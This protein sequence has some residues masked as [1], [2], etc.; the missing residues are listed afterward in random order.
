MAK[1]VVED[2]LVAWNTGQ[3]VGAIKVK[4]AGKRTYKKV[5][6]TSAHEFSALL[7]LLQGPKIVYYD[8]KTGSFGTTKS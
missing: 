5:K 3:D 1:V 6:L 2:Y 4:G 8:D 7:A